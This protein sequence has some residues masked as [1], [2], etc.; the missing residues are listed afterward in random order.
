MKQP[1]IIEIAIPGRR[2]RRILAAML[3]DMKLEMVP[4]VADRSRARSSRAARWR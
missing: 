1:K 4:R 3:P 2:P